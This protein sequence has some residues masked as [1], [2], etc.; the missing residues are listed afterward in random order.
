M[1]RGSIVTAAH[2]YPYSNDYD[3]PLLAELYDRLVTETDDVALLRRLVGDYGP[4]NV[5]E[6]VSGTGRSFRARKK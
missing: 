5:L 6:A 3:D 1:H 4:L 2:D